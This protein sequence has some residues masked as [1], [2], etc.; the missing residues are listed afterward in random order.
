MVLLVRVCASFEFIVSANRLPAT[1]D[2]SFG[3]SRRRMNFWI[4][5]MKERSGGIAWS[6]STMICLIVYIYI[7]SIPTIHVSIFQQHMDQR[8]TSLIIPPVLFR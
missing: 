7:Y 1:N 8:F 4:L 6:P 3:E 2:E 5:R